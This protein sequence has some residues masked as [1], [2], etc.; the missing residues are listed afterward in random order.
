M[1]KYSIT[2]LALTTIVAP[3]NKSHYENTVTNIKEL[4]TTIWKSRN[5]EK[6]AQQA[7]RIKFYTNR[8]Y[9]DFKDNTSRMIDSILKR[10]N[11]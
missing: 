10:N 2:P 8:R 11:D 1:P 7:E 6:N 9:N 5:W 3:N 4:K